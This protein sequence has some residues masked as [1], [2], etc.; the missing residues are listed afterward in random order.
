MAVLA[1]VVVDVVADLRVARLLTAILDG[2]TSG[3]AGQR[4]SWRCRRCQRKGQCLLRS[5]VICRL[6][7]AL[8]FSQQTAEACLSVGT[9]AY[10]VT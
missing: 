9:V 4:S 7:G 2:G 1:V 8:S 10:R 6:S 5:G 3:M